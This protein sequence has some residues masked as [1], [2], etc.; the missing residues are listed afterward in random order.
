MSMQ[1]NSQITMD[2]VRAA[3]IRHRNIMAVLSAIYA[4]R[5]EGG[6]SQ[7][8]IVNRLGLRAPS[9]FRIFYYLEE[10]G[11]IEQCEGKTAEVPRKGRHPSFYSVKPD[12]IYTIGIDFWASCLSLGVFDFNRQRIYSHMEDLAEGI[13]ASDVEDLICKLVQDAISELGIPRHKIAGIGIAAPG[14][15]NVHT[16]TI[17]FYPRIRDMENYPLKANIEKRLDLKVMVHNNCG[18]LSYS[19]YRYGGKN[20]GKAMFAFLLRGGVNGALVSDN[21]I[22]TTADGTTMEAGHI[23][24]NF[25][26]PRCNCGMRGC[27]QAYLLELNAQINK[28]KSNSLLFE[29]LSDIN[30]EKTAETLKKAAFYI[31]TCM[32]TVQRFMSPDSFLIIGPS[33]FVADAIASEV[34][35]L[36]RTIKDHFQNSEPDVYSI[37]YDNVTAQAGASDLVLDAF[38]ES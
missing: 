32:K 6:V 30:D 25:D 14:K 19:V 10:N 18:A 34:R 9:V 24:V 5:P 36:F 37:V 3:D 29:S 23:L 13:S 38:F 20:P 26:G 33:Q 1:D 16:G 22:Y 28:D 31:Y 21:G 2:P 17:I 8:Q 15:I 11:F 12:A 27:L 7:S 35:N 4:A